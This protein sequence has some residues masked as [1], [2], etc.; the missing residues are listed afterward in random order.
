[1]RSPFEASMMKRAIDKGIVEVH[2]HDLRDYATH[3]EKSLDDYPHAL[4]PRYATKIKTTNLTAH[5]SAEL[6]LSRNLQSLP[7][8]LFCQLQFWLEF[9]EFYILQ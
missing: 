6:N 4:E 3:K 9:P 2:F 5:Q 8:F 7:N 1:L